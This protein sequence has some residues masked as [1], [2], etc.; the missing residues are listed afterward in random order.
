MLALRQQ[1]KKRV[2]GPKKAYKVDVIACSDLF[3]DMQ[4]LNKRFK[5]VIIDVRAEDEYLKCHIATSIHI[6]CSK[7]VGKW[8]ENTSKEFKNLFSHNLA[9]AILLHIAQQIKPKRLSNII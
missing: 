8:N 2:K 1:N 5:L 9:R 4:Q 3:N 7:I 6:D